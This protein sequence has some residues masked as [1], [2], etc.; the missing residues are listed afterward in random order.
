MA[1]FPLTL[2]IAKPRAE[3]EEEQERE[4]EGRLTYEAW[5]EGLSG[6]EE[7]IE[8]HPAEEVLGQLMRQDPALPLQPWVLLGEP[9]VGKTSLNEL[10]LHLALITPRLRSPSPTSVLYSSS[11]VI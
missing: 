4:P 9:G 3:R 7:E 10:G 5:R 2:G 1:F 8:P 11:V 6:P